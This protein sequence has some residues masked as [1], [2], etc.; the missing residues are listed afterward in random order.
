MLCLTFQCETKVFQALYFVI[1]S[2]KSTMFALGEIP[3]IAITPKALDEIS[4]ILDLSSPDTR[5]KY[6]LYYFFS[7]KV[8]I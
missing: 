5:E 7:I 2:L 1:K 4:E 6:L 3:K 8:T